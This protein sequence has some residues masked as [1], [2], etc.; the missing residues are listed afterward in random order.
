MP[1]AST[2]TGE[3]KVSQNA[4][5]G[6]FVSRVSQAKTKTAQRAL[7]ALW[8]S[9]KFTARNPRTFRRQRRALATLKA[10]I[11]KVAKKGAK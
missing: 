2:K 11:A 9:G 7:L 3:T 10:N 1:K 8:E 6:S 4:S 5:V